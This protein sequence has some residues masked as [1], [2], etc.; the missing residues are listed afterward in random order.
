MR[1]VR[2]FFGDLV[3]GAGELGFVAAALG[4]DG[5]PDHRRGKLESVASV[6]SPSDSAGVQF[7]DLGH[8]HDL[9][10]PGR[11]DRLR[12][13]PLHGEQEAQLDALARAGDVHGVVLLE[14][15]AK[16]CA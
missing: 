16:R 12:F 13:A 15:A 10:R 4:R 5:Q 3:Q 1:N 8:G 11:V 14:R 7:F 6:R 9:A 2:V